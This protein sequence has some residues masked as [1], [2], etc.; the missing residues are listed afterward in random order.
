V[1]HLHPSS[2]TPNTPKQVLQLAD[3]FGAPRAAAAACRLLCATPPSSL[4]WSAVSA[5][6]RLPAALRELTDFAAVMDWVRHGMM[7]RLG[8]LEAAL[9]DEEAR[10]KLAALPFEAVVELLTNDG[11][12]AASEN[13]CY[14]ER[15]DRQNE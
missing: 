9:G 1:N 10:R 6:Y 13:S 15:F 12:R 2:L 5:A 3:R 7:A 4:D 14:C 11:T 8:D